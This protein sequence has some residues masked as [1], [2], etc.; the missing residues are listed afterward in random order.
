MR[1]NVLKQTP[2]QKVVAKPK[3]ALVI[4][5]KDWAFGFIAERLAQDVGEVFE[6]RIFATQGTTRSAF[7]KSLQ[8]FQPNIIH[9]FWR[10]ELNDLIEEMSD[11]PRYIRFRALFLQSIISF[12]VPDHIEASHAEITAR[13]FLFNV[14]T[15]YVVTSHKLDSIYRDVKLIRPPDDIIHDLFI[16]DA[17]KTRTYSDEK[18]TVAWIGNSRWGEWLGHTDYKG[19]ATIIDPAFEALSARYGDRIEVIKIDSSTHQIPKSEVGN[20]LL[21]ADIVLCA[22]IAEGT[23]LPL[24]EAMQAGCAVVTTDVGIAIDILPENQIPFIVARHH[25]AFIDAISAL[26]ENT[27]LLRDI[28]SANRSRFDEIDKKGNGEKWSRYFEKL[29]ARPIGSRMLEARFSLNPNFRGLAEKASR[30]TRSQKFLKTISRISSPGKR[31]TG[32]RALREIE[33]VMADASLRGFANRQNPDAIFVANPKWLGVFHSSLIL[34]QGCC[35]PYPRL[36]WRD[37]NSVPMNEINLIAS[38]L[39]ASGVKRMVFSGGEHCQLKLAAE[40]RKIA[41]HLEISLIWH[42]QLAAWASSYHR[43]LFREWLDAYNS[44]VVDKIAVMKK[45]MDTLLERSGVASFRLSNFIQAWNPVSIENRA[46]AELNI[47]LWTDSMEYHKNVYTQV[48][49]MPLL[50]I[51][52]TLNHSFNDTNLV[53]LMNRFKVRNKRKGLG[54]LSPTKLAEVMSQTELTLYVSLGECSPMVPLESMTAGSPSLVGPVSD[55]YDCDPELAK[56]LIVD[57]PETPGGIARSVEKAFS[58][59]NHL[60]DRRDSFLT[61][62]REIGTA[63]LRKFLDA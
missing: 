47:G 21:K 59:R 9:F 31:S 2:E 23:P 62:T 26:I 58:A 6:V 33:S 10:R 15:G 36:T 45:S 8:S 57:E 49:A 51:P 29:L 32:R 34:S 60:L 5:K 18:V 20:L 12:S 48:L 38:G 61:S 19:V 42:G 1:V 16:S 30:Y 35:L 39:A 50:D 25:T 14:C 24:L 7:L 22:S 40:L 41:P 53:G 55:V 4:D 13:S 52:A 43:D 37:S 27:S 3:I 54:S 44:G 46:G 63:R 11:N 17:R 28:Q 56:I